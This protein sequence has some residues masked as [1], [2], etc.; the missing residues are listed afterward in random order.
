LLV[1]QIGFAQ[2]KNAKTETVKI[3]GN[4][5]GCEKTIEKAGNLKKE[6][7]VDWNKDTKLATI[8]YN[9]KKTNRDEIL[10]RIALA[11]YDS[12]TYLAPEASYEKL[13]KCCQYDR[14]AMT[15]P[16]DNK[17]EMN[18]EGMNHSKMDHGNTPKTEMNHENMDHS[19]M[20]HKSEMAAEGN[21]LKMVFDHYFE[22]KNALVTTDAANAAKHANMLETA[23]SKVQM[24][25]L[26]DESHQVWMKTMKPLT[27]NAKVIAGTNDVKKQRQAFI[28]LS[29]DM[30]ELIKVSKVDEPVY[31]QFCPMANNGEGANWL[32]KESAVKNPYYGS[33]MLTC[34]SVKEAIK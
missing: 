33:M 29:A 17:M 19:K 24:N 3:Y 11:G 5:G 4:C 27:Q 15:E 2:I 20:G 10:K 16:T 25:K 28:T 26:T 14:T 21:Q 18:H 30:Y 1:T 32:S 7:M 9:A 22:L 31:V 34:G 8:M 6:A 12:D 13:A 23:L